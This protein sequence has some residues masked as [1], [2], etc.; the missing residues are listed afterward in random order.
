MLMFIKTG[1][2]RN[3]K[4]TFY[5]TKFYTDICF[6]LIAGNVYWTKRLK[7][8]AACLN[9]IMPQYEQYNYVFVC[10]CFF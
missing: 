10:M 3:Y 6:K 1:S 7:K 5:N 2:P 8:K 9:K 4:Q